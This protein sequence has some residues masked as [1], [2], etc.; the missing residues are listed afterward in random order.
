MDAM[1]DNVPV[2]SRSRIGV[3]IGKISAESNPSRI[4]KLMEN[5]FNL[6]AMSSTKA[7]R[8][9][10]YQKINRLLKP[11]ARMKSRESN[12]NRRVDGEREE[13]LH[14]CYKVWA[15]RYHSMAKASERMQEIQDDLTALG[16]KL[17]PSEND[18]VKRR[19][20]ETELHALSLVG[21]ARVKS[22]IDLLQIAWEL[23]HNIED[24]R[25]AHEE[26]V[27]ATRER[28]AVAYKEIADAV[29]A[30]KAVPDRK[31]GKLEQLLTS[32][33]SFRQRLEGMIR[34]AAGATEARARSRI[35]Q[36]DK[37]LAQ[38]AYR[39][40]SLAYVR[41]NALRGALEKIFGK[42]I[43]SELKRWHKHDEA[44]SVFSRDGKSP[45]TLAQVANIY[46]Q[47]RQEHYAA[48]LKEREAFDAERIALIERRLSQIPAMEKV[49]GEKGVAVVDALCGLLREIQPELRAAF[50]GVTGYEFFT[51]ENYFPIQRQ[52]A[53]GV[54]IGLKGINLSALPLRFSTRVVSAVDI[55]EDSSIFDVFDDA[56]GASEH[57][58]AYSQAHLFWQQAF[59]DP[60]FSDVIRKHHGKAVLNDFR[61][62]VTTILAPEQLDYGNFEAVN[63][64]TSF[65]AISALGGNTLVMLRQMTGAPAFMFNMKSM[66]FAGYVTTALSPDGLKAV[67]EICRENPWFKTRF[68]RALNDDLFAMTR[69]DGAFTATKARALAWYMITN[70]LGDAVPILFVG[71][72]I[73][74]ATYEACLNKG[75]NEAQAKEVAHAE[76]ARHAE[77]SQQ[78][79][80]VMN[81]SAFNRKSSSIARAV[82]QF[83]STTQQFLSYEVRAISDVMARP[84]D[85]ARWRRLGKVVLL[86]HIILPGAYSATTMLFDLLI[87]GDTDEWSDEWVSKFVVPMLLGP[88]SGIFFVGDA[89]TT[90]GG[91][92]SRGL[93]AAEVI[94]KGRRLW[95]AGTAMFDEDT[96]KALDETFKFFVE[97]I[98]PLRHAY[99]LYENRIDD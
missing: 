65:A 43:A 68:G 45:L 7:T 13:F 23:E 90:I 71:Q 50:K 76:V 95:R 69:G 18:F 59:A 74:R 80:R 92:L 82:Q 62:H 36:M 61:E 6:V 67:R 97:N 4:L 54:G 91:G 33:E 49:L 83:K 78:S 32:V 66:D 24:D 85:A 16:A 64:L 20:L 51:E 55:A 93:P 94:N 87:G 17:E 88:A 96:D 48:P 63:K 47:V 75:M 29:K 41:V 70:N 56:S 37:D 34:F 21:G 81:M 77:A 73:F 14:A 5:G 2:E 26:N 40:E 30:R 35:E 72:G 46:A 11:F 8:A 38:A 44:L 27:K 98:P 39:K 28:N 15:S 57:F 52:G 10:A 89:L 84:T 22:V 25:K 79:N 53:R 58:I 3:V 60:E 1:H 42:D 31:Q 12:L 19:K 9:Q 99:E 86:N